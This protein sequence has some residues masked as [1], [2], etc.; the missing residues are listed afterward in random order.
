MANGIFEGIKILEL[1]AGA[2]GPIATRYLADQGATVVRVES[3]VRPDFL[4]MIHLTADNPHGLDGSPMFVLMNP[5]KQ[6]VAV[7]L[8]T[9]EGVAL[10]R[11]LVAWADVVSE[12]F[13]PKAMAKWGLDYESLRADHPRMIMLSSCLFGQ[14]GPQRM[15]PGFGGQGAALAGFNHL[16]GWP[17]RDA[18][19]PYGT[20]TDSLSPRYVALLIAAALLKRERT[21]EGQYIDVSQIETAV[22]SLSEVVVRCSARGEVLGRRG[23]ECEYA[24]PHGIYPCRGDDRW[25]AIA[26][27]SDEEWRSL[28][29]EMEDA[30]PADRR[31][32][33]VRG[34]IEH[35]DELDQIIGDWTQRHDAHPLMERLQAA[36]VEAG[37]VQD[38][39]D[40]RADPQLAHR[41]HFQ[42]LHHA[43]LGELAFEQCAIRPAEN[44]PTLRAPGPNL[45]EH[46]A[47]F[48]GE[49]LGMEA[50]EIESL[51]AKGVLT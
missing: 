41:G 45:G 20:I 15:Y 50:E 3:S 43:L 36:G 13:S 40:L 22:Y 39:D 4:R 51:V 26:V 10:V 2:A 32:A 38:F 28:C 21:G 18:V 30:A 19:G 33:S 25:I 27:F 5:N 34:R 8:S 49:V 35:R 29:G 42:K 48:L 31:F 17:D 16:T 11:R 6:S 12:N 47:S 46:T 9:A 23:N 14:T 44:P 7:N 1:G 37:A 24:A